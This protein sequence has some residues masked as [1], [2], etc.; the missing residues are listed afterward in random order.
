MPVSLV[1]PLLPGVAVEGCTLQGTLPR[2]WWSKTSAG[3]ATKQP[4]VVDCM[5]ACSGKHDAG[6]EFDA[7]AGRPPCNIHMLYLLD[8]CSM[9]AVAQRW[10]TH[11][12]SSM[13]LLV[14][15]YVLV[16]PPSGS[17]T[18]LQSSRGPVASRTS[19]AP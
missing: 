10:A 14:H 5:Y 7:H 11:R 19:A 8:V 4:G 13:C 6:T 9:L 12:P 2:S 18:L 17:F 16:N 15:M 3:S 1:A